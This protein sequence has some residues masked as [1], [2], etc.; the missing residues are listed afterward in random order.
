MNNLYAAVV[1]DIKNQLAELALRLGERGDAQQE[2]VIAMNAARRLSEMLLVLRQESDLLEANVD[3]VNPADTLAFL[4]AEYRELF[5]G[6]SIEVSVGRAPDFAFFDDALVRM[7]LANAMHNACRFA[8][9]RVKLAAYQKDGMLVFEIS[10]DGAGYP[11]D[12]LTDAGAE[13]SSV[14]ARG[15]GLGLYL[16]RQIAELHHLEGRHG[17]VELSNTEGA[18]FRLVLP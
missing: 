4:A 9:A 6:L 16:A 18:V 2:T 10:D 8:R 17:Y 3:S 12:T 5:P 11:E 15:T 1:H 7:A 13:P 14:S